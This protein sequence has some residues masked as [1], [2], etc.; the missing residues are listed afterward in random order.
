MGP[1]LRLLNKIMNDYWVVIEKSSGRIICHCGDIND[2]IMMVSFDLDNRSYRKQKYLM[3]Q[4]I[5]VNSITDKQLSGQIGLP[6]GK[7]STFSEQKIKLPEGNEPA[8]IV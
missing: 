3:D 8:F 6:E 2:A 7:V 1:F 4:I 5:D